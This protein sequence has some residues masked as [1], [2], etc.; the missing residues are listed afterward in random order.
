MTTPV[1]RFFTWAMIAI[2]GLIVVLAGPCTLFFAG[3]GLMGLGQG[4]D[5][6]AYAVM[7]LVAALVVGGIPLAG[8][9]TLVVV[10]LRTLDSQR[11]SSPR[12]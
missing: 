8:G 12:D 7:I 5:V 3:Q 11:K 10:G 6:G 4:G 2:G 9:I 1:A